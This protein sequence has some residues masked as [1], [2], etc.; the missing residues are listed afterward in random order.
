[1]ISGAK[2]ICV[3]HR[4]S[5][6]DESLVRTRRHDCA[7]ARRS[8]ASAWSLELDDLVLPAGGRIILL[9]VNKNQNTICTNIYI[10]KVAS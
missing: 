5:G 9:A 3:N 2:R 6:A 1:M 10:R 4:A 7:V 8:G